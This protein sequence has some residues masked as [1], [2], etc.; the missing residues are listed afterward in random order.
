MLR[1]AHSLHFKAWLS[2][3]HFQSTKN[4]NGLSSSLLTLALGNITFVCY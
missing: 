1:V 2:R 3:R 4:Y